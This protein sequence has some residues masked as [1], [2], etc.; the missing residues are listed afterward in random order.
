VATENYYELDEDLSEKLKIIENL[1]KNVSTENGVPNIF[2][3][4]ETQKNENQSNFNQNEGTR[5]ESQKPKKFGIENPFYL[6]KKAELDD[7]FIKF[8]KEENLSTIFSKD[9]WAKITY[10]KDKY[11]VVGLIFLEDKE[12]YICSGV[13]GVYSKTPPK[14]LK[15]FSTFIPF[16]VFDLKGKGYWMTFQDAITGEHVEKIT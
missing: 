6:T 9:K 3:Q 13:P 16:S 2:G 1:T 15:E 5:K 7:I 8:P 4:E 11:Y 14:E 10:A 12:K